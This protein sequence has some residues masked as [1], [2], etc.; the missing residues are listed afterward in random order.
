MARPAMVSGLS[1][2]AFAALTL[3]AVSTPTLAQKAGTAGQFDYWVLSLSWSPSWCEAEGDNRRAAECARPFSFT[4]HGLWPQYEKGYPADCPS[5]LGFPAKADVDGVLPIMPSPGLVRYE[6][7]KH[8]TCSGLTPQAYFYTLSKTFGRITIP[9]AYK[10][11]DKDRL[12]SPADVEA[13]FIA[14]NKIPKD[15]I[16]VTCD[17]RRLREVR[18]CLTKS[19]DSFR[20]CPE[21]DNDQCR[22]AQV[23]LPAVR[24]K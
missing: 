22:A 24:G 14:A 21:V 3:L 9:E 23:Y 18:I 6:W 15:A 8:G 12:V 16:S 1:R 5:T 20:P 13:D 7:K 10:L 11:P 19:L 17:G 4:V 2:A